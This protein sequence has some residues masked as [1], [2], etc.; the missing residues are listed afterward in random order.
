MHLRFSTFAELKS[1]IHSTL[2]QL[3]HLELGE[4]PM[5]QQVL[6][7]GERLCGFLFSIYGP[8]SVVFNAVLE[9]ERKAIHFYNSTGQRVQTTALGFVPPMSN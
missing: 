8:R 6:K 7:R 2:C 9:T 4:F 1:Y 5:T 3:E